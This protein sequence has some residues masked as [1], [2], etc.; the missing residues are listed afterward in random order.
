MS[1]FDTLVDELDN[2]QQDTFAVEVMMLGE[3]VEGIFDEGSDEFEGVDTMA[4]TLEIP[5]SVLPLGVSQGDKLTLI[6]D[7]RVFTINRV[8]VE[9]KLNI[10][11]LV[12]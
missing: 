2:I 9:G 4:I 3:V 12:D 1:L 7:G 8:L 6:S 10:L 11:E 5:I